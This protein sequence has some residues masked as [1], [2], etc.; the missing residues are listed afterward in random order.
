VIAYK[1]ERVVYGFQFREVHH[2]LKKLLILACL[3]FSGPASMNSQFTTT[4][5]WTLSP[6]Y[7]ASN[8][9]VATNLV[10]LSLAYRN[11]PQLAADQLYFWNSIK[12][13]HAARPFSPAQFGIANGGSTTWALYPGLLSSTPWQNLTGQAQFN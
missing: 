3:I 9:A 12:T 8:L 1:G 13:I 2:M 10:T 11:S 4:N 6:T 5:G 7:G